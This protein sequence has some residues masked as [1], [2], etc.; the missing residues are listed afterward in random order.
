M[1]VVNKSFITIM[2]L[3]IGFVLSACLA[4]ASAPPEPSPIEVL[5]A[6]EA[7]HNAQDVDA[8]VAL[9]AEDG[10]EVNPAGAWPGSS[11]L[12]L[13]Y[14]LNV[15]AFKVEHTN[16][17]VDGNKVLYQCTRTWEKS[18]TEMFEYEAIIE[19]G[20]IKSNMLVKY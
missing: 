1:R 8:A 3:L 12:R 5:K 6:L 4:T 9:F 10:V 7:A 17:Q 13:I 20:K 11:K 14:D 19:D 16:Y 15:Q 18:P 2:I